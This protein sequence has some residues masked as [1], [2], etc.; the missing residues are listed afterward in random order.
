MISRRFISIIT[1]VI[2]LVNIV[3]V[4]SVFGYTD[5]YNISGN[6]VKISKSGFGVI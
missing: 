2:I 1:A 4:N 5:E 3:C 6:D